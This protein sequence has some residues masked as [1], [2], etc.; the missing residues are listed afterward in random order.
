MT[1]SY[2]LARLNDAKE[3]A[4]LELT[5]MNDELAPGAQAMSGQHFTEQ[6][7]SVLINQGWIML[8]IVDHAII[9]YVIAGPWSIFKSWPIY[10]HIL[11]RL[12]SIEIGF[13]TLSEKNSCQYG[14]IWIDS[15]HRGQ[16]IFEVLVSKLKRDV[17]QKYTYMVTFIAEDNALSLAAHTRKASMEVVDYFGFQQRDYYLLLLAN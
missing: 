5:H 10:Q 4:H 3:I 12:P 8:A 6:Q 16:G 11:K 1:V 13:S 14:P 7:L 2:R 15:R 9:G 17:G